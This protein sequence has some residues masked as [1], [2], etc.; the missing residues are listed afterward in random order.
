MLNFLQHEIIRKSAEIFLL[1]FFKSQECRGWYINTSLLELFCIVF[2]LTV[3]KE[4]CANSVNT[5]TTKLRDLFVT[6]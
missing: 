2:L 4:L 1:Y 6:V 5:N 3:A